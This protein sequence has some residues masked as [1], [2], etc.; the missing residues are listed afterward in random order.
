MCRRGFLQIRQYRAKIFNLDLQVEPNRKKPVKDT[1][2]NVLD[3][4]IASA[5]EEIEA[6]KMQLEALMRK[7]NDIDSLTVCGV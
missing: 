5:K 2:F 1:R 4:E 7:R 6:M 3:G